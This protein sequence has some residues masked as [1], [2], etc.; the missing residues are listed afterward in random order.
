MVTS[1]KLMPVG[2]DGQPFAQQTERVL[3]SLLPRLQRQFPLLEEDDAL[4][5]TLEEAGRRILRHERLKGA[6]ASLHGYA[7]VTLRSVAISHARRSTGRLRANSV[8][9]DQV[10]SMMRT[11]RSSLGTPEQIEHG[12][13]VRQLLR[14]LTPQEQEMWAWKS[15]GLSSFEIAERWGSTVAAVDSRWL[16]IR[17]KLRNGHGVAGRK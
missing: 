10:S 7:W 13:L 5:D 4:I 3:L 8:P 12:V 1:V 6:I 14:R 11:A 9:W 16:R 2:A 17:R 15:E